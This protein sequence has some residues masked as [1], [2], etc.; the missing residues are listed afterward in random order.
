M[1]RILFDVLLHFIVLSLQ[2]VRH[3]V[4]HV[5]EH[6]GHVRLESLL[7][8]GERF[9]HLRESIYGVNHAMCRLIMRAINGRGS[10]TNE[11]FRR[12]HPLL[13]LV[14]GPPAFVLHVQPGAR[15]RMV[16]LVPIAYLVDRTELNSESKYNRIVS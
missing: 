10:T 13:L 12:L 1:L 2:I 11:T 6:F 4:V 7:G 5:L 15:D 14:V 8:L 16:T 9:H 3:L